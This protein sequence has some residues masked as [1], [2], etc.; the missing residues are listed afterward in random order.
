MNEKNEVLAAETRL[1]LSALD[2]DAK[3]TFREITA[4]AAAEKCLLSGG[5]L[6]KLIRC[7]VELMEK[8]A[9]P[10]ISA[11]ARSGN[12]QPGDVADQVRSAMKPIADSYVE[13][14]R[15][16]LRSLERAF[17][18]VLPDVEN[19]FDSL[20]DRATVALADYPRPTDQI[21]ADIA[22]ARLPANWGRVERALQKARTQ[23]AGSKHEEDFQ[24][25]GVLCREVLISAAQAVYDPI[26]HPP[27]DDIVPSDSDAKRHLDSYF[28]V[29]LAGGSNESMRRHARSALAL[30]N[31]L[32]HDRTPSPLLGA[33]CFEATSTVINLLAI[34]SV[35]R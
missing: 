31:G 15:K 13:S 7:L 12:H 2:R 9:S 33:L 25:V 30:A 23:L 10:L 21:I 20:R 22:P 29:E 8:S 34:I 27:L 16:T 3:R 17:D 5:T 4:R 11:Y 1:I 26:R 24:L 19:F 32:Q 18:S 6:K 14:C 28:A 35:S